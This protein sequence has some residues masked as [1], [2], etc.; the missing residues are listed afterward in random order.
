MCIRD[1]LGRRRSADDDLHRARVAGSDA[2]VAERARD[3]R[4]GAAVDVVRLDRVTGLDQAH[5]DGVRVGRRLDD[6][7]RVA[8]G[9][10]RIVVRLHHVVAGVVSVHRRYRQRLQLLLRQN[11]RTTGPTNAPIARTSFIYRPTL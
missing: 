7:R 8:L 9:L 2:E 5:L 11:L 10:S 3:L 1:S 6:E 4:R